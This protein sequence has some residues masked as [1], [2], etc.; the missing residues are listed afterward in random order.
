MLLVFSLLILT[1]LTQFSNTSTL[2]SYSFATNFSFL[3]AAPF[4]KPSDDFRI[5]TQN[6]QPNFVSQNSTFVFPPFFLLIF[7]KQI[8]SEI[9]REFLESKI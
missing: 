3:D 6:S 5:I 7:N 2:E 8:F 1:M 4:L 9:F